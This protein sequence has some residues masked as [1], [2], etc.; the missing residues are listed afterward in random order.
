LRTRD[1]IDELVDTFLEHLKADIHGMLCSKYDAN[2]EHEDEYYYYGLDSDRD[3]EEEVEAAIR[4]FPYV[5]ST[6][7]P[8]R[9]CDNY[10]NLKRPIQLLAFSRINP[11]LGCNVKAV[12]FLPLVVR[13]AIEFGS[14]DE[15]E[16]G[17][18]LCEANS[19][20]NALL[21]LMKSEHTPPERHNREDREHVDDEYLQHLIR[22]DFLNNKLIDLKF[23]F[24]LKH[25][26]RWGLLKKEDIQKYGLLN[27]LCCQYY[28]AEH[29]FQFLTEWD[30][31]ALIQSDEDG[32]LPLHYVAHNTSIEGFKMVFDYGIRYHPKKK[33]INLLFRLNIPNN[34]PFQL[35][36]EKYGYEE[37]MKIVGD[38]LTCYSNTT[39]INVEEALLSAA[40]DENIHLD[41]VYFVLRRQPDVLVKLLSPQFS[42]PAAVSVVTSINK[43]N[44][45]NN[46]DSP[47][48]KKKGRK[49]KRNSNGTYRCRQKD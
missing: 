12:S 11:A 16:R 20:T 10:E 36:C 21:D 35:A 40:I 31:N 22:M 4:L 45:S 33:G 26:R 34:T 42:S 24:V 28:V 47:S 15:Q 41:N 39:P 6:R 18:L 2:I 48:K 30:P 25:L 13:L 27:K 17:G 29:R 3:T 8:N 19:D 32:S 14:F 9:Y 49:R 7:W 37:V 46:R 1:K 38:T 44:D 23:F 43:G 5:L